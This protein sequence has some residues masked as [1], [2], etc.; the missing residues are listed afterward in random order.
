MSIA[1]ASKSD[2]QAELGWDTFER[3]P[4]NLDI[5]PLGC[6]PLERCAISVERGKSGPDTFSTRRGPATNLAAV[7]VGRAA[8]L[9]AELQSPITK[10]YET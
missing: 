4:A 1:G 2:R 10:L 3:F 8:S 9:P 7:S 5:A 6:L